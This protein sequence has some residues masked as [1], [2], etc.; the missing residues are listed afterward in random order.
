MAIIDSSLPNSTG[1]HKKVIVACDFAT[2]GKCSKIYKRPYRDILKYR[3][4]NKGKDICMFCSRF[5]K[6]SGRLNPNAKYP[7]N[8]SLFSSVQTK[9]IAYLLGLIASEGSIT[10]SSISIEMETKDASDLLTKISNF[11]LCGPVKKRKIRSLSSI[12]LNSTSIVKDVLYLLGLSQSGAKS[13][14]IQ[15]P[16]SLDPS[17]YGAFI[18]GFLDGDGHIPFKQNAYNYPVVGLSSNSHQFLTSIFQIFPGG[19]L[20][21]SK[22]CGVLEYS[23][24]GAIDFLSFLYKDIPS[25]YLERKYLLYQRACSWLPT[26]PNTGIVLDTLKCVKTDSNAVLPTKAHATDSGYDLTLIKKHSVSGDTI[27]YDTGLKIQPPHGWWLCLAPRSS[28]TK[29]GYM[30]ANSIGIIDRTY[31]GPILVA[32]KKIDT[33]AEELVLPVKLVQVIPMP[34]VHFEVSEV[35]TVEDTHRNSGGFGSSDKK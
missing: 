5:E 27:F 10:D 17:L 4:N 18:L 35:T 3:Q 12:T 26:L 31:T 15:F 1:S 32:L 16:A 34:A 33:N 20:N 13:D 24:S 25:F 14:L 30:L 6:F 28:I 19:S 23:G 29:T 8:D 21:L 11:I 2:S 7:L 9:E 22:K